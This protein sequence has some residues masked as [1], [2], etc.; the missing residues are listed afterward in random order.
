MS[1]STAGA[2]HADPYA[3]V[4]RRTYLENE[5]RFAAAVAAELMETPEPN[6]KREK[7]ELAIAREQANQTRDRFFCWLR[8]ATNPKYGG[9]PEWQGETR[10]YCK[11]AIQ[12]WL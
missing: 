3:K 5:Y 12:R 6:G 10:P 11:H 7:K 8:N 9:Y 4:T 1:E 2:F